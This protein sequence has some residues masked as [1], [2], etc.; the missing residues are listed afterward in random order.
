MNT[1]SF[2]LKVSSDIV[3]SLQKFIMVILIQF[4]IKKSD[5][6]IASQLLALYTEIRQYKYTCNCQ[7]YREMMETAIDNED[8]KDELSHHHVDT[9][10]ERLCAT[11]KQWGLTR[12][13]LQRRRFSI[14]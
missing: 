2:D 5:E 13:N 1:L 6:M 3:L 14:F 11:L 12:I 9:I 4:Q 10:P 8:K 7:L